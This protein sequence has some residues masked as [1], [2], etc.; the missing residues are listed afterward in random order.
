MVKQSGLALTGGLIKKD[1]TWHYYNGKRWLPDNKVNDILPLDELT[2][3]IATPKGISQIKQVKMTLE[4]KA[5][6]FEKRIRE[7]HDRYG[8]VSDSRLMK[9]GD[10][11]SNKTVTND[12]DGLWTSIYLAAECYRYAVTKDPE[13]KEKAIKAYEAMERLETITGIPGFPA[14]V[15]CGIQ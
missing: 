5:E 4:E 14:Q 15:L 8:L 11:S 9:S 3:W 7:R 1:S 13:A 12:N 6:T 10:L 2:V